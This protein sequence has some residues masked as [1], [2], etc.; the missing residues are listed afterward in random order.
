LPL[1]IAG[2][3]LEGDVQR[4]KKEIVSLGLSAQVELVGK[5]SGQ[6]K[7]DFLN[8]ADFFVMSSRIENF[9]LVLLEAFGVGLP[10]VVFSINGVGW[11]PDTAALKVEPFDTHAY[12]Q[13]LVRMAHNLEQRQSMGDAA[14]NCA[15][16]YSWD[17]ISAEYERVLRHIVEPS[18]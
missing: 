3:G 5:L 13:A 1:K 8:Q 12:A 14:R 17:N 4:L 10:A 9:A 2:T 15:T 18:E 16:Q 11:V 6:A 7:L